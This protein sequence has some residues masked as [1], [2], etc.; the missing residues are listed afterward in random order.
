MRIKSVIDFL[1]SINDLETQ[2]E[3]IEKF[4]AVLQVYGFDYYGIIRQPK[5]SEDP[6]S[7]VLAGRWPEGWPTR[8]MQKNMF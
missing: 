1:D 4:E 2:P 5:A 3:I 7:L 6:L 8:Y